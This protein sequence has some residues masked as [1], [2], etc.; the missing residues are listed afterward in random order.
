MKL[1]KNP[2]EVCLKSYSMWA[3]YLGL[4][5]LILPELIYYFWTIDTNPR[6]WW[7]LGV[8]LI[9]AATIGRNI[10]QGMNRDDT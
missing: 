6:L 7:F 5:V 9:V 1:I 2:K 4:F 3:N 10:D 8:G